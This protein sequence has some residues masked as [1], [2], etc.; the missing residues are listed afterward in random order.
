MAIGPE[1]GTFRPMTDSGRRLPF[2]SVRIGHRVVHAAVRMWG[3]GR[4]GQSQ[5]QSLDKLCCRRMKH[6][7][8]VPV[9]P[10][11]AMHVGQAA[12]DENVPWIA[13]WLSS[14]R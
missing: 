6:N 10:V 9:P 12:D 5:L 11:T 13:R 2:R 8:I 14:F 4:S 1:C 3:G 7:P